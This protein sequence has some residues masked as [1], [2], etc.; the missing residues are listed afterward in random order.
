MVGQLDRETKRKREK[1][2]KEREQKNSVRARA[3]AIAFA[4]VAGHLRAGTLD[5]PNGCLIIQFDS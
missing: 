4:Y 1:R 3:R 2:R 5:E